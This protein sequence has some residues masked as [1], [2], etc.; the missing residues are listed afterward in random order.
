M[1]K[2]Y[3]CPIDGEFD[4]ECNITDDELKEC[5]KCHSEVTR[6]FKTANYS[7]KCDGFAGRGF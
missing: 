3:N 5:P 2:T 1:V 4:H 7:W 6:V